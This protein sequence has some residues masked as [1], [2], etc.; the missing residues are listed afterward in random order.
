MFLL[1]IPSL[2]L[3]Q[4]VFNIKEDF[5]VDIERKLFIYFNKFI[6]NDLKLLLLF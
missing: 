1:H 5:G 3:I 6:Q 2:N 4:K